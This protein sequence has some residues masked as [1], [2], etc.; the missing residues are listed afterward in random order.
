MI[1]SVRQLRLL[2]LCLAMTNDGQIATATPCN[3]NEKKQLSTE[4]IK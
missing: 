4:K 1:N 3:D 2:R